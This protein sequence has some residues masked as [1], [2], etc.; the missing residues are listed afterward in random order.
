MERETDANLIKKIADVAHLVSSQESAGHNALQAILTLSIEVGD[1]DTGT[2]YLY[3]ENTEQLTLAAYVG[4]STNLPEKLPSTPSQGLTGYI[5]TTKAGIVVNDMDAESRYIPSFPRIRSYLGVP[6]LYRDKIL[7]VLSIQSI[8]AHHFTN[9]QVEVIKLLANLLASAFQKEEIERLQHEIEM[10]KV[11]PDADVAFVLTPFR[12]PFN[13]YYATIIR[14]AIQSTGLTP[15]RADEIYAPTEIIKDIW[16]AINNAK[17]I[18]AELT[19]RNPNVMYEL[20]LSHALNRPVIM[21]SQ[22]MDDVPF[23][24][25]SLRCI[26]YDTTEPDWANKLRSD[27][28][29]FIA[30]V[31]KGHNYKGPFN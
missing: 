16:A 3:D 17:V 26:L 2:I 9:E 8:E 23:D 10:M 6:I 12:E 14:P 1:G 28:A 4:Q 11:K 7:G 24:L 13:K 19:T 20:G 31:L 21:I 5:L 22:S 29:S 15:L 27:I 25:R 30:S 18:I